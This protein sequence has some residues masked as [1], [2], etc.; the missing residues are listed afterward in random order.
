MGF[1]MI[2]SCAKLC[3][4]NTATATCNAS[5]PR[6]ADLDTL[7]PTLL[8]AKVNLSFCEGGLYGAL[9]T[10]SGYEGG[11]EPCRLCVSGRRTGRRQATHKSS[12]GC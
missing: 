4:I 8:L 9:V 11:Y 7:Y 3:A 6:P 2:T 12:Q 5:H 10:R 1:P